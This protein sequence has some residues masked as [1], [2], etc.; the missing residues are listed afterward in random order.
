MLERQDIDHLAALSRLDIAPEERDRLRVDLE[1]ILGYVSELSRAELPADLA[2]D[3]RPADFPHRNA[4][5]PDREP[6][7]GGENTAAILSQA[8]AMKDN[9]LVVKK[10]L[11]N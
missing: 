6:L 2:A 7:P 1:A 5:R 11:D 4:L 3:K 10:I 8:P 9:Y